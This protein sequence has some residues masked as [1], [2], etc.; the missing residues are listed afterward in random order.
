MKLAS[1]FLFSRI[2]F[3][4]EAVCENNERRFTQGAVITR[5]DF[6]LIGYTFTTLSAQIVCR[7]V[8]IV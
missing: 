1:I 4:V 6:S 2:L 5:V 3:C 8:I 7:V